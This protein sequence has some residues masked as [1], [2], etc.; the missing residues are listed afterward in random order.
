[1]DEN[2]VM[3]QET[4]TE[5]TSNEV[6]TGEVY[7]SENEAI[8]DM[9]DGEHANKGLAVGAGALMALA[10]AAAVAGAVKLG[11]K[12]TSKIKAKIEEKKAAADEDVPEK[13]SKEYIK[14]TLKERILGR[15]DVS[16]EE[17]E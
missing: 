6:L 2:V 14:L 13:P 9:V 4:M 16:E 17:E 7:D 8:E 11:K 3:N 12:A 10:G 5:E 1:M 15:M